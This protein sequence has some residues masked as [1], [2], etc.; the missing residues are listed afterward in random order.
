[1]VFCIGFT[2]FEQDEINLARTSGGFGGQWS[3]HLPR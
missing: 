2:E 3:H 1:M